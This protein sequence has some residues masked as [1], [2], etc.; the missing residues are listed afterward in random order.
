MKPYLAGPA[1]PKPPLSF[2]SGQNMKRIANFEDKDITNKE[3][4]IR[5][6]LVVKTWRKERQREQ[7]D[8]EKRK[9]LQQQLGSLDLF[10][11]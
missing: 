10:G 1:N 11:N 3:I 9:T 4:Q 5:N 2:T 7:K 8:T 6:T